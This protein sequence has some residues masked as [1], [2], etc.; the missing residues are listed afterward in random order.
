MKLHRYM[1]IEGLDRETTARKLG[2][3]I[4]LL[5]KWLRRDRI[6]RP[7]RQRKIYKWSRGIVQPNDW[8][9]K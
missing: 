3:S 8:I 5:N 4:H 7:E 2:V 1:E 6:P 9:L